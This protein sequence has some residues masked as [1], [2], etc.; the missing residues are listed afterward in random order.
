M[1]ENSKD[2]YGFV[3]RVMDLLSQKGY[4]DWE[5]RLKSALQI[6]F[7]PGEIFGAVGSVF[8]D[9]QKTSIPQEIGEKKGID[10]IVL[11]M[12]KFFPLN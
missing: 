5:N 8:R 7:M 9:L 3:K 10:E 4:I 11:L 1:F 12:N 6:S 2:F